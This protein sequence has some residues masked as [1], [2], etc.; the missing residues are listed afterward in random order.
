MPEH[1]PPPHTGGTAFKITVE[2][3]IA[4]DWW[5]YNVYNIIN[6][7]FPELNIDCNTS[8]IYI[9]NEIIRLYSAYIEHQI[10]QGT[11]MI[12]ID[13][14]TDRQKIQLGC[15]RRL[16]SEE[17]KAIIKAE[18]GRTPDRLL[19]QIVDLNADWLRSDGSIR[20]FL[21]RATLFAAAAR[22]QNSYPPVNRSTATEI[23]YSAGG[24]L[25]RT[26]GMPHESTYLTIDDTPPIR[27][28]DDEGEEYS[29]KITE[30]D[31]TSGKDPEAQDPGGQEG[32]A[33]ASELAVN[34]DADHGSDAKAE[35]N[36]SSMG[37]PS[38]YNDRPRGSDSRET[39][40]GEDVSGDRDP[41]VYGDDEASS[42]NEASDEDASAR[43]KSDERSMG[44]PCTTSQGGCV[45]APSHNESLLDNAVVATGRSRTY[46]DSLPELTHGSSADDSPVD[47]RDQNSPAQH[48]GSDS[49]AN[50][51][52][53]GGNDSYHDGNGSE[54]D[55]LGN[56]ADDIA[57]GN[58]GDSE[59]APDDE[60]VA[61]ALPA[62]EIVPL[63]RH[64]GDMYDS[65]DEATE[66]HIFE[67]IYGHVSAARSAAVVP[68]VW[69]RAMCP[70]LL[71]QLCKFE[72]TIQ[73]EILAQRMSRPPG[74]ELR[75]QCQKRI[76][77]MLELIMWQ[78]G[79][80]VHVSNTM[81]DDHADEDHQRKKFRMGKLTRQVIRGV[82]EVYSI[83][84]SLRKLE[85]R[86]GGVVR[87]DVAAQLTRFQRRCARR[88]DMLERDL[89]VH[90]NFPE[91]GDLG[92][93]IASQAERGTDQGA[94]AASGVESGS[95]SEERLGRTVVP[96]KWWKRGRRCSEG[97]YSLAE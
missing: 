62:S 12:V 9:I 23:P 96:A 93:F 24:Q 31:G 26:A 70:K 33:Q 97:S 69:W 76:D 34:S 1:T 22:S 58:H 14:P 35:N 72:Q 38:A 51:T 95:V 55:A 91:V 45:D 19:L 61:G 36:E 78:G 50:L 73:D 80:L 47:A 21:P 39:G 16:I 32:A 11:H 7:V 49:S 48:E 60:D 66:Q 57:G 64:I 79:V 15:L 6:R 29:E 44:G 25:P 10:S 67:E 8:G 56:T 84:D 3:V 28:T 89:V 42:E 30:G 86:E 43:G 68:W 75:N 65:D 41:G 46:S 90:V 27:S 77:Q 63:Q 5:T 37:G 40:T 18:T 81:P 94:E 2:W 71:I 85:A 87:E 4:K 54:T 92:L 88:R 20:L 13:H 52:A 17:Q 74:T 83:I 59:S 53:S 82:W